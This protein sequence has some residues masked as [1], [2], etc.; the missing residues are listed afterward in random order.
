MF[1]SREPAAARVRQHREPRAP[2]RGYRRLQ[3]LHHY[4]DEMIFQPV[5][6]DYDIAILLAGRWQ[7]E[8]GAHTPPARLLL[9]PAVAIADGASHFLSFDRR[10]RKMAKAAGL[11]LLPEKLER[12]GASLYARRR[13]SSHARQQRTAPDCPLP[14]HRVRFQ[15]SRGQAALSNLKARLH[16]RRKT[17]GGRGRN[18][19]LE[20]T[21]SRAGSSRR[22]PAGWD[23]Q[24]PGWPRCRAFPTS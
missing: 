5:H 16:A 7:R 20:R 24:T 14:A 22:R 13:P 18:P 3:R 21:P 10:P 8:L 12:Q 19:H 15:T 11:K 23:Q 17:S 2:H 6:V 4:L 1:P 9:W